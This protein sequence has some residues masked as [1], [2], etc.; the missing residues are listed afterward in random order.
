MGWERRDSE[1]RDEGEREW[2]ESGSEWDEIEL[3]YRYTL[4]WRLLFIVTGHSSLWSSHLAEP[5]RKNS[6]ASKLWFRF[7]TPCLFLFYSL[8]LSL[9]YSLPFHSVY[10]NFFF[11]IRIERRKENVFKGYIELMWYWEEKERKRKTIIPLLLSITLSLSFQPFFHVSFFT[12]FYPTFSLSLFLLFASMNKWVR[13]QENMQT[14]CLYEGE[15]KVNVESGRENIIGLDWQEEDATIG[16]E[17]R[18]IVEP[19]SFVMV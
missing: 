11:P 12:A 15:M 8:S 19:N 9:F 14:C 4:D 16:L 13:W 2:N 7:S 6:L 10:S 17:L 5:E 1:I 3:Y 18:K